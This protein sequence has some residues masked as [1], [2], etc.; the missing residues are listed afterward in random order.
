MVLASSS[1]Y[2]RHFHQPF[3]KNL[4]NAPQALLD[5]Q[6]ARE[7]PEMYRSILAL[8]PEKSNERRAIERFTDPVSEGEG[9]LRGDG[10]SYRFHREQG[11][12]R[13]T[14]SRRPWGWNGCRVS[15]SGKKGGLGL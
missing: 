4:A 1:R 12:S 14:D 6:A 13:G 15:A 10:G 7:I 3:P 9:K 11:M 5:F 8:D 2:Q